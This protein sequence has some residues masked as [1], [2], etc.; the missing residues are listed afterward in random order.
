MSTDHATR[1]QAAEIL[2]L[3]RILVTGEVIIM[4]NQERFRAALEAN[5]SAEKS[6]ALLLSSISARLRELADQLEANTAAWA[7]A[8]V[9]NTPAA[10]TTPATPAASTTPAAPA[11]APPTPDAS[12]TPAQAIPSPFGP[13]A[14][15]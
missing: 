6:A 14:T 11:A 9:A 1:Q 4:T 12:A 2:R 8:V 13:D 3:L 15:K 5:T 7:A 10:S